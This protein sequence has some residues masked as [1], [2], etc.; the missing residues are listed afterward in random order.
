MSRSRQRDIAMSDVMPFPED[1][2]PPES[3]VRQSLLFSE[4]LLRELALVA[5]A[6][7][8]SL[9]IVAPELFQA[10]ASL[11]RPSFGHWNGLLSALRAARRSFLRGADAAGRETFHKAV[12]LQRLLDLPDEKCPGDLAEDLRPLGE[13][14]RVE[15]PSSLRMSTVLSLP[16][17]LR[18]QASHFAPTDPGWWAEAAQ[19]LRPL[20]AFHAVRRLDDLVGPRDSLP[21]PWFER[22][23]RGSW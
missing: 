17:A 5:L 18:N 20:M 23:E 19:R 21:E 2:L 6:D 16:I 13:F 12:R 7:W 22:D 10:T 4:S 15:V 3:Y 11:Q 8:D 1:D 9:R 14:V